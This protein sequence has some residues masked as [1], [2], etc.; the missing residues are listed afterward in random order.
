MSS[1][2][3]SWWQPHARTRC[4]PRSWPHPPNLPPLPH[5]SAVQAAVDFEFKLFSTT[6]ALADHWSTIWFCHGI[7]GLWR[8]ERFERAM[9]DHPFLPFG[10]D[11][12]LGMLNLL[13][14]CRMGMEYRSFVRTFAPPTLLPPPPCV[15]HLGFHERLQGYG[16]SS[17]WKQRAH[18]WYVNAPRRTAW[19]LLL[20]L[21][22]DCGEWWRN[23][24]FRLASLLHLWHIWFVLAQLPIELLAISTHGE[25]LFFA[26]WNGLTY[27]TGIL[28]GAVMNYVVW[29]RSP[30]RQVALR[31]VILQPAYNYFLHVGCIYG[32][33][34]SVLYYIPCWPMEYRGSP[35]ATG[36]GA[37][38]GLPQL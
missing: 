27:T 33:W 9:A 10:E 21:L 35:K 16:A 13:H 23:A 32:H 24:G 14:N 29:R 8:R 30:S 28:E 34:R 37:G 18:R 12:W 31:T 15:G 25:W 5:R 17:V 7:V 38:N 6:R 20:L 26:L 3:E 22:Y 36:L 2:A 1:G 4:L 11:N 19:R